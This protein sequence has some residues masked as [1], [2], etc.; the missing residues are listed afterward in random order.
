MITEINISKL[1]RRHQLCCNEHCG[2]PLYSNNLTAKC[3][4][5]EKE[6]SLEI[7]PKLLGVLIDETGAL[8]AG[9]RILNLEAWEGLLGRTKEELVTAGT[10]VL[11]Y[12]EMRLLFLRITLR[13]AWVAEEGEGG[14]GR[15][16]IWGVSM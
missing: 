14:T 5:C 15:L 12:L 1:H 2:H 7:N 16:C 8:A 6:I 11:K 9:K 10:E 4:N 13:F 3:K